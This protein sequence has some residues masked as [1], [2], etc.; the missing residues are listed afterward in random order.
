M[1]ETIEKA[2]RHQV[3]HAK[4]VEWLNEMAEEQKALTCAEMWRYKTDY[5]FEPCSAGEYTF[6]IEFQPG[7]AASDCITFME[8][9][10][11]ELISKVPLGIRNN[12]IQKLYFRKRVDK[13]AFNQYYD[14]APLIKYLRKYQI[15]LSVPLSA[16]I[17]MTLVFIFL[18]PEDRHLIVT[19][20]IISL[21]F[22][23]VGTGLFRWY[24]KAIREIRSKG[25]YK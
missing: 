3:N 13:G 8:V 4:E 22:A 7:V 11:A 20:S 19:I 25:S 15:V 24:E 1:K 12:S 9:N 18:F 17:L 21:I 10:G 23:V 14:S 16:F 6:H 5:T 2:N